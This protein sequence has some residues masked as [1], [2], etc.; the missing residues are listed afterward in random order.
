MRKYIILLCALTLAGM[1]CARREESPGT[2][3]FLGDSITEAEFF[4]RE[5]EAAW[6]RDAGHR[7]IRA[8][9]RGRGSESVTGLTE[10]QFTGVRPNIFDRLDFELKRFDPDWVVVCYGMNGG[11]F[12]PY[13]ESAY[14]AYQT[15]MTRLVETAR[16]AGA[17]VVV[18]TPPPFARPGAVSGYPADLDERETAVRTAHAEGRAKAEHDPARYGYFSPYL[19]YDD[20]LA[21]YSGWL[22]NLAQPGAVWVV[23]LRAPLLAALETAYDEDDPVH[24]N[25][26]GHRIMAETL[27]R[28]WRE[29]DRRRKIEDGRRQAMGTRRWTE[30]T[31]DLR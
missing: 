14:D 13:C 26:E 9:P 10:A 22:T 6:N 2:L 28:E 29:M 11:L 18:L 31:Q 8:I 23:D 19:Y 7:A 3:L 5:F 16:A 30:K 4:V 17:K 27:L 20:V 1:G 12:Q 25:R 21:L 24:P 15:G